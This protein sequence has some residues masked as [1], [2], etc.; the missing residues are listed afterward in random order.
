[1]KNFK[2]YSY[3]SPSGRGSLKRQSPHFTIMVVRF[4]PITEGNKVTIYTAQQSLP[5][6]AATRSKPVGWARP[7]LVGRG[8]RAQIIC[9]LCSNRYKLCKQDILLHCGFFFFFKQLHFLFQV[10]VKK[11]QSRLWFILIEQLM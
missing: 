9:S 1:M 3:Q 6:P 5:V 11:L 8:K 10:I 4:P 2:N 7:C